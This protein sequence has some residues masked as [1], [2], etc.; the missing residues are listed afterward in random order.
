MKFNYIIASIAVAF[1]ATACDSKLEVFE[2]GGTSFTGKAEPVANVV[3]E[4]LPGQ[5]KLSWDDTDAKYEYMRMWYTDPRTKEKVVKLF[6]PSRKEVGKTEVLIDNTRA[7]YG[8]YTFSF[9]AFNAAD[10]GSN[11]VEFKAQSGPAPKTFTEPDPNNRTKVNVTADMLSTDNQEPNE[12]PISNLVDGNTGSFF[13]TRWSGTQVPLPQYVQIDFNEV[14]TAFAIKYCT[15]VVGNSDGYPTA[16]TMQVQPEGSDNWVDVG[17]ISDGMPTAKN[18]ASWFTSPWFNY[19]PGF[20]KFRFLV[21]A[22]TDNKNYFHMSE[23]EFYDVNLS[24]YDPETD[25]ED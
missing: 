11:V 8:D 14:H 15:R 22:V 25:E 18:T 17:Y 2:P 19:E 5:I 12:G 16:A 23:F 21:T 13:H 20:K 10:Q 1:A 6:S 9:Q 7:R 24:I 4:S 3:T